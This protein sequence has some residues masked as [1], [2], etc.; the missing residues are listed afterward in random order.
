MG[1][2]RYDASIDAGRQWF[3]SWTNSS[4]GRER[5]GRLRS[6]HADPRSFRYTEEEKAD[7]E[8]SRRGLEKALM[9]K[10]AELDRLRGE[11]KDMRNTLKELLLTKAKDSGGAAL[12]EA[13]DRDM[14]DDE[15]KLKMMTEKEK[16]RV[17]PRGVAS[18]E[19]LDG[20]ILG[21]QL[22]NANFQKQIDAMALKF[23]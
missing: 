9:E 21:Q 4:R 20:L 18:G 22:E 10:T 14:V 6:F 12:A 7:H 11:Y 15:A 1:L 5:S 2:R 13:L 8:D 3:E 23:G 17:G 16:K 19:H